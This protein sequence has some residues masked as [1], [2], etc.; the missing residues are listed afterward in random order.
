MR[1]APQHGHVPGAAACE[2]VHAV[3]RGL[4]LNSSSMRIGNSG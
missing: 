3:A 2:A 1:A 4:F